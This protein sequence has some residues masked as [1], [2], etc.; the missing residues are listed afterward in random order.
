MAEIE[1]L[2]QIL[3]RARNLEKMAEDNA[4]KIIVDLEVNGYKR[5]VENIKNDEVKHQKIVS[6]LIKMAE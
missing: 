6:K 4:K 3:K 5:A 1:N 2:L